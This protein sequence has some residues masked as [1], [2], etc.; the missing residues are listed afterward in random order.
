[1]KQNQKEENPFDSKINKMKRKVFNI[2]YKK[3]NF[4]KKEEIIKKI[5]NI[6][7]NQITKNKVTCL[8]ASYNLNQLKTKLKNK[9]KKTLLF[10]LNTLTFSDFEKISQKY[11]SKYI[12][13]FITLSNSKKKTIQILEKIIELNNKQK[14]WDIEQLREDVKN[15]Y[16]ARN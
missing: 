9:S 4:N 7:K 2:K 11:K 3:S 14:N 5:K 15:L 12:A 1:M 13:E 10:F 16:I 6:I 8:V